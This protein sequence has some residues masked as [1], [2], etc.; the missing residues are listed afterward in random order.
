M[1]SGTPV[2]QERRYSWKPTAG[3]SVAST[4]PTRDTPSPS[5]D[6]TESS[7]H[8]LEISYDYSDAATVKTRRTGMQTRIAG[9]PRPTVAPRL[10]EEGN[11]Q[12]MPGY[13]ARSPNGPASSS[14]GNVLD[15]LAAPLPIKRKTAYYADDSF[16]ESSPHAI[17]KL[18]PAAR[19]PDGARRPHHVDL[20]GTP[21]PRPSSTLLRTR[22]VWRDPP[23]GVKTPSS[24]PSTSAS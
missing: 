2:G 23:H 14:A 19:M 13:A 15:G 3:R 4:P 1:Q 11:K 16:S 24:L 22:M 7:A 10:L 12:G 20:R 18:R 17:V 5:E 21:A 6:H 8:P 9:R